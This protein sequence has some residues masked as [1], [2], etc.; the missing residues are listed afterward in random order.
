MTAAERLKCTYAEYLAAE[1]TALERHDFVAGEVYAMSGGT[2]EHSALASACIGELRGRLKG[3]P[4]VVFEANARIHESDSDFTC[5]PD[6]S[7]VCGPVQRAAD[8]ALA[9]S[10]PVVIIEILSP[11]TEAYDRGEKSRRYRAMASVKE[12]VLVAQDSR[13]VEVLRRNDQGRFELYEWATGEFELASLG[14]KVPLAEV[15]A[16]AERL[17][18]PIG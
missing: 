16:D 6:V 4:C 2:L 17:A 15:Y 9:I 11:T 7:V 14:L 3:R 1:E 13:R 18:P 10:N 8:D 5:Y 12:I